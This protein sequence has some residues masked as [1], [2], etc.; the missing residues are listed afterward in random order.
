MSPI[1]KSIDNI[2][3][4]VGKTVAWLIPILI[5]E[6]VYDTLARYVFNSPTAW[7]YDISYMLYG[8]AFMGGASYT[9]LL[10][11]HVRIEIIYERTSRKTRAMIDAA[12]YLLFFF[13]S[14]ACLLYFGALFTLKSW[15]LHET[16]G[17]SM[18]SP[19]IYPFKA[20]IPV[21]AFLLILQGS[22]QFARCLG[23]IAKKEKES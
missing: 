11:E 23:S 10:N 13:P 21:T 9:L 2:S 14:M 1:S 18:W 22:V 20:T 6:L 4:F 12:G 16:S 8:A 5:L 3:E 17:I 19:P 15:E 7:S